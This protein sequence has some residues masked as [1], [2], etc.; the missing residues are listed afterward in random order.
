MLFLEFR[1][2]TKLIIRTHV[3]CLL[4]LST[5]NFSYYQTPEPHKEAAG[6]DEPVWL[7][8]TSRGLSFPLQLTVPY[9]LWVLTNGWY[10]ST[11]QSH[12]ESFYHLRNIA[13]A[14]TLFL[15]SWESWSLQPL[16]AWPFL[17]Y[18]KAVVVCYVSFSAWLLLLNY[19]H[20]CFPYLFMT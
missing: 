3:S 14:P 18:S 17:E 11:I 19:V 5:C 9:I 4:F 10:W 2:R 1:V 20:W 15:H 16:H 6:S 12:K 8:I 7:D 13:C